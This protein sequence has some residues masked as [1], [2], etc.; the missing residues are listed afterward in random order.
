MKFKINIVLSSDGV[1][2]TN[3]IR[4][5]IPVKLVFVAW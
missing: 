3:M 1:D 2:S 5:E 4:F